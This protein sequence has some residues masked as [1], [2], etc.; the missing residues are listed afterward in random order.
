MFSLE[1][2]FVIHAGLQFLASSLFLDVMRAQVGICLFLFILPFSEL[3]VNPQFESQ[4]LSVPAHLIAFGI[5]FD[6]QGGSI[7]IIAF[8][9]Y[10]ELASRVFMLPKMLTSGILFISFHQPSSWVMY[11]DA[12]FSILCINSS[13]IVLH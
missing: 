9:L 6:T 10:C 12:N 7:Y 2:F 4:S 3:R 13:Y 1:S 11:Y 5:V 8:V